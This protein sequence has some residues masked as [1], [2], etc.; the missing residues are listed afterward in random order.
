MASGTVI[1]DSAVHHRRWPPQADPK[2]RL[3][4]L[5]SWDDF[6]P[7]K[8]DSKY[9][10]SAFFMQPLSV[11][12]ADRG[13]PG[14]TH[15]MGMQPGTRDRDTVMTSADI[16]HLVLDDLSVAFYTGIPDVVDASDPTPGAKHTV[17]VR[18]MTVRADYRGLSLIAGSNVRMAPGLRPCLRTWHQGI[19]Q[20]MYKTI[21]Q[22]HDR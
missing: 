8:D 3:L 15:A 9:S 18:L 21:Y 22:P 1:W 19:K 12:A 2:Y 11:P 17:H 13:T 7:H 5:L 20:E 16:M 14:V 6:Q 4:T 10:T